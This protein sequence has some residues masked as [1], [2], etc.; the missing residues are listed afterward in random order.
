MCAGG[1]SCFLGPS[2]GWLVRCDFSWAKPVQ[3]ESQGCWQT[4]ACEPGRKTKQALDSNLILHANAGQ[5]WQ[6][7]QF[8]MNPDSETIPRSVEKEGLAQLKVSVQGTG[9]CVGICAIPVS[10]H[11]LL[12]TEQAIL[13]LTTL[14]EASW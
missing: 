6:C 4:L 7:L 9:Q 5:L 3:E 1:F 12:C 8:C 11:A 2:Q 13:A 14:P 10:K